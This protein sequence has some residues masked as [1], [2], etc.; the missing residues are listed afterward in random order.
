[1]L[2]NYFKA[3][4]KKWRIIG[5]ALLGVSA[6][7]TENALSSLQAGQA[8]LNEILWVARI[9]IGIGVV[10]K[11]LTNFFKEDDTETPPSSDKKPSIT[12]LNV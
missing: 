5:D 9:A 7:I 4:P 1:M 11:F 3:T 12:Y 8:D 10:G 2:S 6:F